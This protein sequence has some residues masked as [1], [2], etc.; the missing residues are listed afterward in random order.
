MRFASLL[1]TAAAITAF[2]ALAFVGTFSDALSVH[3]LPDSAVPD[4]PQPSIASQASFAPATAEDLAALAD[5]SVNHIQISPSFAVIK[6]EGTYLYYGKGHHGHTSLIKLSDGNGGAS[7]RVRVLPD[8]ISG[9]IYGAEV[10]DYSQGKRVSGIP[11]LIE[12]FYVPSKENATS[13]KIRTAKGQILVNFDESSGSSR[14][15]V[16]L[17]PSGRSFSLRNTE[18]WDG[19]EIKF[20]SSLEAGNA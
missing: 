11:T 13:Y 6:P 7:L 9:K 10:T 15:N 3:P 17:L 14:A 1:G 2:A 8:P 5:Y 16:V 20:V 19:K 12:P 18:P 4:V